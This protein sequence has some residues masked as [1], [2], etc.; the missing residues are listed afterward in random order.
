MAMASRK[1]TKKGG[2]PPLGDVA[3]KRA[4]FLATAT[5]LA[6]AGLMLALGDPRHEDGSTTEQEPERRVVGPARGTQPT[7]PLERAPD[8]AELGE[9]RATAAQFARAYLARESGSFAASVRSQLRATA[10]PGTWLEL[11]TPVRLTP[12]A[13]P[14]HASFERVAGLSETTQPGLVEATIAYRREGRQLYISLLLSRE[15][16]QWRASLKGL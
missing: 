8:A 2:A 10:S 13:R 16:G 4:F 12:A 15:G 3:R 6:I 5:V 14:P 7:A 11:R 9:V 1:P